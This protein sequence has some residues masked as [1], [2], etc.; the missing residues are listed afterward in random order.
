[1]KKLN[2]FWISI[3]IIVLDQLSKFAVRNWV[4]FGY[5]NV[6]KL[7][8]NF[9]WLTKVQNTGAAFSLSFGSVQLNRIIFISISLVAV[10]FLAY[11]IIKTSSKVEKIAF[12]LVLGGAVGNL[13]DRIFLG[14]VTD[15]I[16]WDFPDLIMERWPVFNI[17]DSAIVVAMTILSIY[18]FF[19]MKTDKTEEK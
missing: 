11:Y 4:D 18:Y 9:F 15:F 3:S 1:M 7:T 17:A 13:L 16:W 5:R 6:I 14:S 10:V 2:Y 19:Y 8:E 12:S